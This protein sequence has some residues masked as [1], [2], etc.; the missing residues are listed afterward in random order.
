MFGLDNK[1]DHGGDKPV[2][3]RAGTG[4]VQVVF[5]RLEE[6]TELPYA[7]KYMHQHAGQDAIFEEMLR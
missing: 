6:A 5:F 3:I 1:V 2:H 7:G 4:V